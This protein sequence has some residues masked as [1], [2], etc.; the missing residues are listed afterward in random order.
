MDDQPK[1]LENPPYTGVWNAT[2]SLGQ[3]LQATSDDQTALKTH[4][5]SVAG[6]QI[7]RVSDNVSTEIALAWNILKTGEITQ[8]EYSQIVKI[9]EENSIRNS[10]IPTTVLHVLQNHS[11]G[12]LEKIMAFMSKDSGIPII[13]LAAFGI[14]RQAV[15]LLGFE[16][17]NK[18]GAIPFELIGNEPMVALLNPYHESLKN[19]ITEK[20][21]CRCH[22]YLTP[23]SEYDQHLEQF[24]LP[25]NFEDIAS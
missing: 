3:I 17:T 8:S 11:F 13:S 12:N 10:D 23:A 1:Q 21:G 2:D 14:N 22:F 9:L 18:K 19:E 6:T 7:Q 20:L 25:K 15:S 24:H 4:H 5:D 16:F